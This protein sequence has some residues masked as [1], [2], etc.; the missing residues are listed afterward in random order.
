[1]H[2]FPQ[3][4]QGEKSP[5]SMNESLQE[6]FEIIP[7]DGDQL[8]N[9]NGSRCRRCAVVGNSG[10]LKQSQ[11]GQDIDAHDFVFR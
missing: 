11:Y 10:N 6:L 1:M 5:K 3:K 4:L 2:L 9:G 7:G 8:L